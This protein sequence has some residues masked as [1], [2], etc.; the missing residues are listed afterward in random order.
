VAGAFAIVGY[1][2]EIPQP[3]TAPMLDFHG[4]NDALIPHSL[5]QT[6]C[7]SAEHVGDLCTL[8]TYGGLGHDIGYTQRGKV[9]EPGVG[10]PLFV[11]RVVVA[12]KLTISLSRTSRFG[13]SVADTTSTTRGCYW[14]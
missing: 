10:L 3:G 1:T 4:T 2:N 9:L 12:P 5:A 6:S 8:D 14:S 13:P 7:A 11:D